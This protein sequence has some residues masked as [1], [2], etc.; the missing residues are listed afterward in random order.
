MLVFRKRLCEKDNIRL[1]GVGCELCKAMN[2]ETELWC[3]CS[4]GKRVVYDEEEGYVTECENRFWVELK[5]CEE[6]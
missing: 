1:N 2:G 6:V 4:N 5:W 3:D